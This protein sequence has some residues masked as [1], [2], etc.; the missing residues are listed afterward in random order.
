MSEQD[1]Q[2]LSLPEFLAERLVNKDDFTVGYEE[3]FVG[4]DKEDYGALLKDF[5]DKIRKGVH[6]YYP[7]ETKRI[8]EAYFPLDIN[9]DKLTNVENECVVPAFRDVVGCPLC[10]FRDGCKYENQESKK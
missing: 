8:N 1:K 3:S 6:D 5:A 10:Q 7:D 2:E 4:N 9:S